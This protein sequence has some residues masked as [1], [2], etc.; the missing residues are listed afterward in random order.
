MS[1]AEKVETLKIF[2]GMTER[3]K[4]LVTLGAVLGRYEAAMQKPET[5]EEESEASA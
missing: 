2:A 1:R 3:D 4:S 5:E